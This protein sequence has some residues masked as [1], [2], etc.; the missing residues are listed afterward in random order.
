LVGA[1]QKL[2]LIYIII[3]GM[4]GLPLMELGNKTSLEVAET[5]YMDFLAKN[6]KTGLMYTVRKGIAP[7]SDVAVV[8]VLGYDP[9]KYHVSRGVLEAVGAGLD[10]KNGDLA[11][12]ANFGTLTENK[13]S[14]LD[15]R[16][17]R[18]LKSEEAD[19]L[20]N[21]IN[22]QVQLEA[23]PVSLELKSTVT[24]RAVLVMRSEKGRLSGNI[25]NT[26]PAYKRISGLGVANLD[27][28]MILKTC[29]P[30]DNTKE[31]KISAALINE[32]TQKATS[33]LDKHEINQRRVKEGK[34][35]AN[36]LLSRDAGSML[37][38][39]PSISE[40][41]GLS[42]VCLADMNVERGI[43]KLAGMSLVDLPLPSKSLES[44]CKLRIKK[45]FDVIH[46]YD[47][48][49]IHIKGPDE[50]GHDGDYKLKSDLIATID[51]HFVGEM[52]K[53][54]SL[55]DY[56]VCIT[57]DHSTP[58]V[59]KSHSDDPVPVLIAGNKVKS[60]RVQSFSEKECKFGDLGVL[61][62]GTE[63]IPLLVRFIDEKKVFRNIN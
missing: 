56:T 10:F 43:S 41:F 15:R 5:P 35:K 62:Q 51:K 19:N 8:S 28:E 47:S 54:I 49:Y 33:V 16:A 61:T 11:I 50:P 2:K 60:D 38:N 14:L 13:S 40:L 37:P 39:F 4:G 52:L 48:F 58:C 55:D 59:L 12:R 31:A 9:F 42:F 22:S 6:G 27:Y 25:S 1:V 46:L 3:D 23:Y 30:L 20:V 32:F 17:G 7:E 63:L 45:L 24:Y 53:R 36:V 34:L 26:D 57:A 44:D 21:A 18:N 29:L